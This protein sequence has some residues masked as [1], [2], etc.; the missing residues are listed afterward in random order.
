M[1]FLWQLFVVLP[2][3]PVIVAAHCPFANLYRNTDLTIARKSLCATQ[4]PFFR[5]G[6]FFDFDQTI[7]FPG[8]G[9]ESNSRPLWSLCTANIGSLKTSHVWKSNEDSLWC[10]Q[11]TQ[12]GKNNVRASSRAVEEVGKSL[13]HGQ[14][15]SGILRTDGVHTT[16]HGG[17]A[18]LAP[19]THTR[20]FLPEDD[21]SGKYAKVFATK[22]VNAV[23]T[24]VS[25]TVRALV[26]SI[27]AK[28]G[29]SICHDTFQENDLLLSD[30][31]EIVAQFG[32]I[33]IILAG[34]M[35]ADPSSYPSIA[36]AIHFH[37]WYDPLLQV[38]EEGHTFRPLTFSRD[39][40]FTGQGD[41]CSS[42]DAVLVNQV[43]FTAWQD[44]Q[45]LESFSTQHRTIRASFKWDSIFQI[46]DIHVKFAPLD[47]SSV[48]K[49]ECHNS[50]ENEK[51]TQVWEKLYFDKYRLMDSIHDK[52]DLINA[53]C[54][55]SLI[56]SGAKWGFGER[57][58]GSLPKFQ[59]RRICPGQLPL[60]R[61]ENGKRIPPVQHAPEVARAFHQS[62]TENHLNC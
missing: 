6:S 48:P 42:I 35:Q 60:W 32:D 36:A 13:F 46:G 16:M 15:M 21:I 50:P 24:Q 30:V 18:I 9:P 11:E 27:Y 56:S 31:F 40:T 51:V 53:F 5:F 8:E 49:P 54:V 29:A 45:A 19:N 4:S 10:L 39:C 52:W 3:H 44:I 38:D 28:S 57:K 33:P 22:R 34:D 59:P 14:L 12:I 37:K 23:W 43:A 1:F 25:P 20:A 2:V 26:F 58:R 17:T 55:D 62:P 41:F 47:T 7:G 61:S